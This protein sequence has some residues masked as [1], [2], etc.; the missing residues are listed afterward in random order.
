MR[1]LRLILTAGILSA[2]FPK[3]HADPP[4]GISAV[5]HDSVITSDEVDLTLE[6]AAKRLSL[7]YRDQP[8]LFERKLNELRT[9]NRETLL[10]QRLILH[11][12]QT[13]GY[14]LPESILDELVQDEIRSQFGD[15]VTAT[16]SLQANGITYEKFRQQV[17]D[18]FVITALR[19]K[20]ISSEIIIS[21]HKVETYYQTHKDNFKVED[22]VKL[23]MIELHKSSDPSKPDARKMAEEIVAKLDQGAS[24]EQMAI[25]SERQQ[26]TPGPEVFQ[27]SRLRKELADVAAKLKP[28]EHSGVIVIPATS[29]SPETYYIIRLEEASPAHVKTLSEVRDEIE[30]DLLSQERARLEKQWIDRLRK[31]T[32]VRYFE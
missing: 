27:I 3:L 30:R 6:Q 19:Q 16:K 7:E 11:E 10:S 32:F 31:K 13:A 23:R 18:R 15:R 5:V 28:G 24:F 4:N 1:A 14:N 20:N 25:P 17:R 29:T 22:E 2:G 12:F 26:R 8:A 9:A 21:P